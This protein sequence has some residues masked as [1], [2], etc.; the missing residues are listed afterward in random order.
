M[1]HERAESYAGGTSSVAAQL[2]CAADHSPLFSSILDLTFQNRSRI[3]QSTAECQ[4]SRRSGERSYQ[5]L[6]VWN[7]R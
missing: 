2:C 7:A 6:G 3:R 4:G 1:I 5:R